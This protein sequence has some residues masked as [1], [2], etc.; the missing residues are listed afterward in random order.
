[1]WSKEV[2][3]LVQIQTKILAEEC[4]EDMILKNAL[5]RSNENDIMMK[6]G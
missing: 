4:K 6:I 1:M 5:V 3:D 2:N